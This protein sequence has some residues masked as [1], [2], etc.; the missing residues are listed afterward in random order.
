MVGDAM[1]GGAFTTCSIS[2]YG[3]GPRALRP[4]AARDARLDVVE[5]RDHVGD[6]VDHTMR[7]TLYAR[8]RPRAAA[9]AFGGGARLH[10]LQGQ[11]DLVAAHGE[12][13]RPHSRIDPSPC[14]VVARAGGLGGRGRATGDA[15]LGED[16]A[17]GA[18]HTAH[19]GLAET[20]DAADAEAVGHG[21]LAGIDH[22]AAAAQREDTT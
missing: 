22:E 15:H 14:R 9:R 12:A 19:L 5:A 17:D 16:V 20:A 7:A 10:V 18:E 6:A 3:R 11:A 13:H 21:E 8:I 2:E 1:V 4:L